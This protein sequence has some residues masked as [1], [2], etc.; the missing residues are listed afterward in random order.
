MRATTSRCHGDTPRR[1][2]LTAVGAVIAL[3]L[4]ACGGDDDGDEVEEPTEAP[5]APE[6]DT[7]GSG[8][9]DAGTGDAEA[10]STAGTGDAGRGEE[11]TDPGDVAAIFAAAGYDWSDVDLSDVTITIGQLVPR[12]GDFTFLG[13]AMRAGAELAAEQIAAAG[14]PTI[15]FQAEDIGPGDPEMSTAGARTLVADGVGVIQSSFGPA[16]LA[17]VPIVEQSGTLLFQTA[18]ATADQLQVSEQL[19]M[20]RPTA[21]DPFP[22]LADYVAESS[23]EITKAATL[24]W[25]EGS[26]IASAELIT[27]RWTELGGE[28]TL[29]ELVDV[30]AS[31]MGPSATRIIGSGAEVVFLVVFGGDTA[32]AINALR[33]GGFEGDILGVDW[34]PGVT[35]ATGGGDNGFKYVTDAQDATLDDPFAQLY[36]S[37]YPETTGVPI[38]VFSALFWDNTIHIA[39]LAVRVVRAGGDPNDGAALIEALRADPSMPASSAG[40]PVGWDVTTK[41]QTIKP[42]GFYEI[43]DG[44]PTLTAIVQDGELL[45][46]ASLGDL[47]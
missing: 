16:T 4:A 11:T 26:S 15:E 43:V 25:N 7:A 19:W 10:T 32:T 38:D 30:G 46:G 20:G 28:L 47:E 23:P 13:D 22:A 33:D 40:T 39:E 14:G 41:A 42:H 9:G 34:N 45:L 27:S 24:V 1:R 31:D 44:V 18:G 37:G 2:R 8:T 6:T 5:E 17:V 36:L 29:E 21:T 12:S 3:T 35:E